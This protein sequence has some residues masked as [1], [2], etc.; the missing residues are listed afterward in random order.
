MSP[1]PS[2]SDVDVNLEKGPEFIADAVSPES[3]N[4]MTAS[5]PREGMSGWKLVLVLVGLYTGAFL[6]GLDT[7][8]AA[9]IQGA[10]YER[11][12]N[13]KDL[14]WVGLGFP[15]ASVSVILLFGRGYT[16]FD[17]K[18]LLLSSLAVFEIG[19][20]ICGAAPSS[21]ALVVG[22]VIAGAGG[23]GMYLGALTY[24][25]V[26]STPAEAALY[27]ALTGLFWGIGTIVG[28]VIGGAF[29]DSSATWRWVW[30]PNHF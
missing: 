23:A 22:R 30:Q 10:A 9:D 3:K 21:A 7:T 27:N 13:I 25:A 16:M 26:Y 14:P 24:V 12:K 20:A 15:M 6:Y 1:T 19:S 29:S 11:F 8:I 28:P 2:Q 4:K 5:H 17:V 18:V